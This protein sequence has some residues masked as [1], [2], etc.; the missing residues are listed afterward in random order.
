MSTLRL[1]LGKTAIDL[2]TPCPA[3]AGKGHLLVQAGRTVLPCETCR[4]TG[5]A[6][7]QNGHA[8]LMMIKKYG[9]LYQAI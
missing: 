8:I 1:T 4:G 3:C 5:T 6:L 9:R 2:E 7:T